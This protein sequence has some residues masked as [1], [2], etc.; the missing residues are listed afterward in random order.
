MKKNLIYTITFLLCGAICFSSCEDMLNVESNRVEYDFDDWTANDSVYSVLGILKAVQGVGDR[1][2][3]F[4]ELRA[5]LLVTS[6]EKAVID[7]QELSNSVFN[8]ESNAYLDV[9]DY[10]SIINNCNIYLARVDTTIEKNN[11]K[12]MLPEYVAVKSIRAWTYLQLTINYNQ[13][14]Y[15][16]E[17]ILSHSTAEEVM[18][19][20]MLSREEILTNLIADIIAYE[21]PAAYPMPAWDPDGMVL[22]FGYG[23]SGTEV[24]T[25]Q[26]FMPIRMLLGEMYLWRA[27]AGD[28][29]RAAQCYYDLITGAGTNNTATKYTDLGNISKYTSIGGKSAT[30]GFAS[31]FAYKRFS[32]NRANILALIPYANNELNGTTSQLSAIFAPHNDIGGAQVYASPGVQSLAKRQVYYY[33]EGTNPD[34]PEKQEYSNEENYEFQGDLRI[35]SSTFSQVSDDESR[36]EYDNIICKYNLEAN[37]LGVNETQNFVPKLNST[38][39]VLARKEQLYLRFAEAMIGMEREGY[40]GAMQLAMSVLKEG[41]KDNYQIL[42]DPVYAERYRINAN[43]DT[44]KRYDI[45]KATGDTLGFTY[46]MEKY[47]A[48]Y[49]DSLGF[50]FSATAFQDNNGMHSRGSGYSKG[51]K[52]YALDSLCIARYLGNVEGEVGKETITAPVTYQDSLNYIS[53]ILLDELALELAWEGYRFGDLVRFATAMG[54]KD[55]LAKRIA[56]R[57]FNNTVSYRNPEFQFDATLYNKMID[58]NNLYLH[59][60]GVFVEPGKVEETPEDFD[61]SAPNQ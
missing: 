27:A 5:D 55:V 59:L 36:T 39:I 16:T 11:V 58:E 17:P 7:V 38:L 56:G 54:D 29:K 46:A 47:L 22:T 32:S 57:A 43:G 28:Y 24:E 2:V 49:S 25:R 19:R 42:K 30:N 45:D 37:V 34:K 48:S 8:L 35:S 50:D 14:P 44:I 3:L 61:P 13:V 41:I 31:L 21:N 60:P 18:N 40:T 53:D 33:V 26:L 4:N 9:K 52:Y 12:L 10:Y 1:Q 15:F 23:N 51:N 6:E 20:P